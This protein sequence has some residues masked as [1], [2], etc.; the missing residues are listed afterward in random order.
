MAEVFLHSG[1]SVTDSVL[2]QVKAISTQMKICLS[3]SQ[4]PNDPSVQNM[5]FKWHQGK[6]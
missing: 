2:L 3:T 6:Y 5:S 1:K 4:G